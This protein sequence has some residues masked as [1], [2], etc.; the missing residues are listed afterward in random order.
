M[1]IRICRSLYIYACA[2]VCM[3]HTY[4]MHPYTYVHT[5]VCMYMVTV[6][7]T[8]RCIHAYTLRGVDGGLYHFFI[9]L[10]SPPPSSPPQNGMSGG[11][12]VSPMIAKHLAGSYSP[13]PQVNQEILELRGKVRNLQ[14]QL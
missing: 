6:R 5:Y 14:E 13:S 9:L 10:A 4:I 2:N 3:T 7:H 1:Y 8:Q 12:I 11:D